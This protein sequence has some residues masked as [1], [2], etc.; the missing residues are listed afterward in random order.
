[1]PACKHCGLPVQD[2]TQSKHDLF[3]CFGCKMVHELGVDGA[4]AAQST[5]PT[6]Y[7]LLVLRWVF[8]FVLSMF[9]VFISITIFFEGEQ[10]PV[11]LG[12]V[13]FVLGTGVLLLLGSS[14]LPNL[15]RELR[16][17]RLSLASLIFT[18]T[19]AAYGLSVWSVFTGVGEPYFETASMILTFY[20]GSLLL[21]AYFKRK[22]AAY[23]KTFAD[24]TPPEVL[25]LQ[26][27]GTALRTSAAQ[28]HEG[29]RVQ[30]EPDTQIW[31]DGIVTEGAGL[32]DEAHL[33]GEA[34]PVRKQPGDAVRAGSLS[35]DGGLLLRVTSA[36]DE[37]SLQQYL[38]RVREN[39]YQPGRY[40]RMAYRGASILLAFVMLTAL[41]VLAYYVQ[42]ADWQIALRNMLAVLLIGC[43]CAFSISTPAA[44]WIANQRLQ[45]SGLLVLGGGQTIERLSEIDRVIFDKTGTLTEGLGLTEPQSPDPDRFPVEESLRLAGGLEAQQQHP[46]AQ[47]MRNRLEQSGLRP[48]PVQDTQLLPGLGLSGSWQGKALLLVNHTHPVSASKLAPGELGLFEDGLLRMSF[49]FWQP[50]KAQL[51]QAW[52]S[53]TNDGI[54]AIILTGDPGLPPEWAAGTDYRSGQSPEDKFRAVNAF[55]N[56]GQRVLFAGDGTNDML[57]SGAADVGVVMG[58][59]TPAAK[60]AADIIL[61]QPDLTVIPVALRFARKVKRK[62]RLNFFWALIYNVVGMSIAAAGLLHPF[63]AILAMIL[64]S[65]FVTLNS[66]RIRSAEPELTGLARSVGAASIPKENEAV[67]EIP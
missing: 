42:T 62:I 32:V 24:D 1:M 53:L 60:E 28:V 30:T 38:R 36:F 16:A 17:L 45:D 63:F 11:F 51:A 5:A 58:S 14:F 18:G 59:G 33:T 8:A 6:A 27:N 67:A 25:L 29:A 15:W 37:S 21:D 55:R 35:I 57:A 7:K 54:S 46:M 56:E 9:Q 66:L 23:G 34:E 20:I 13:N 61:L 3:C 44:V 64:S 31:L 10:A 50:P 48:L 40:E 41:A 19:S 26:E 49:R 65:L 47:A 2:Y 39:R 52:K 43:P 22:L 12:W 4:G